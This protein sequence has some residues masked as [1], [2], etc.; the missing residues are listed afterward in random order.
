MRV[1][2]VAKAIGLTQATAHRLLQGLIAEQ[3]WWSRTSAASA[4]GSAW[5]FFALAAQRGQPERHAQRCAARRCCG[6][7]ASLGDTVF[8]LVRTQLR[9]GLRG[10][11]A[12]GRSRSAPSP[13]TSAGGWRWAWARAALAILAFQP[14]DE[15]EESDP[16]QRAA[17]ARAR[18]CSDE[19][20]LRT[21]IDR[22]RATRLCRRATGGVL[23]DMAGVAVP[24]LDRNQVAVAA[25]SVGTLLDAAHRGAPADR[26]AAAQAPGRDHRAADEPV[27]RGDARSDPGP[28]A[29]VFDARIRHGVRHG[30][31][32]RGEAAGGPFSASRRACGPG[33][34][35]YSAASRCA[36]RRHAPPPPRRRDRAP[37]RPAS[38]PR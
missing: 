29:G 3:A 18:A 22:V 17:H 24:I 9:R 30:A 7:A 10:H 4:T 37:A 5:T 33:A 34:G 26:G 1:T 13:A 20:Y 35:R 32:A 12:R 25:L 21:E 6:C 38:R 31:N 19:V 11:R 2:Q 16:L 27:R 8:L 36:G 15:R 14:E 23:E 28:H